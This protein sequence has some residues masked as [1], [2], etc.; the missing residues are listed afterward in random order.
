MQAK[1]TMETNSVLQEPSQPALEQ[2]MND[3]HA[4][5]WMAV[6]EKSTAIAATHH[7]AKIAW[8]SSGVDAGYFFNLVLPLRLEK[9]E[10]DAAVAASVER[11]RQR[12]VHT[13]WWTSPSAIADGLNDR[14]EAA[15][16][17]DVGGPA[18]MAVELA[19][20]NEAIPRPDNLEITHVETEAELAAVAD[21]LVEGFPLPPP[22]RDPILTGLAGHGLG[23]HQ[24]L[25]HY[26]G[27]VDGVPATAASVMLAAGVA[28]IY[29]VVTR[30]EYRG[31]GLGALIT[32]APLLEARKQ[33]YRVG[34]LQASAMGYPVYIRLGFQEV[35]HYKI[36]QWSPPKSD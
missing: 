10:Q 15:G 1:T 23:T 17:V 7:D 33:G 16:F 2:A 13:E 36:F 3:N 4:A 28:G 12:Q 27:Y 6:G 24:D 5:Y 26:L 25:H 8:L 20:L 22:W 14:L 9:S 21:T 31:K 32:L 35:F 34:I 11:A 18:A 19:R 30:P 29:A